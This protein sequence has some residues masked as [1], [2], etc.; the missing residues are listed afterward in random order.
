MVSRF[1]TLI[2]NPFSYSFPFFAFCSTLC[3]L[4]FRYLCAD[5]FHT[6]P[7]IFLYIIIIIILMRQ[8][9]LFLTATAVVTAAAAA[10]AATAA[11][12]FFLLFY[13]FLFAP[14]LAVCIH[15]ESSLPLFYN[16]CMPHCSCCRF[17][18]PCHVIPLHF[19]AQNI[20]TQGLA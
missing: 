5:R 4:Q 20:C 9:L 19:S 11:A 13:L 18:C 6:Y 7:D 8:L 17:R 1:P 2:F 14:H 16:N 10:A 3:A 15:F 12:A